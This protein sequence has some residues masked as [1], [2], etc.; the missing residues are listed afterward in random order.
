MYIIKYAIK[1]G[2]K[3]IR[4]I[5]D[6]QFSHKTL[7][8]SLGV[9]VKDPLCNEKHQFNFWSGRIPQATGQL[10]PCI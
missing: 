10:S 2:F 7:R 4:N 3:S 8:T 5:W 9:Q 1:W 6:I